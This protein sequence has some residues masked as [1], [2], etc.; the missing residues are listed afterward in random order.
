MKC[1]E[2]EKE[3]KTYTHTYIYTH[4]HIYIS[5]INLLYI[6]QRVI[7]LLQFPHIKHQKNYNFKFSVTP[8]FTLKSSML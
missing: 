7:F 4:T 2:K 5:P 8:R 6:H 3:K 1:V